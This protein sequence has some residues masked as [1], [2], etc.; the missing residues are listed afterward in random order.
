MDIDSEMEKELNYLSLEQVNALLPE[1]YKLLTKTDRGVYSTPSGELVAL[2]N[3]KTYPSLSL[4]YSVVTDYYLSIGVTKICFSCSKY[5]ALLVP[6]EIIKEY[7]KTSGWKNLNKGRSYHV[8][9]KIRGK[10]KEFFL[11]STE[12]K[13]ID[14][15]QYFFC[16]EAGRGLLMAEPI[17][18]NATKRMET[19]RKQKQEQKNK[20]SNDYYGGWY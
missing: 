6:I 17:I 7:N 10:K 15:T 20:R 16:D 18:E 9:M 3:S 13:D 12:Q 2:V 19:L 8:R 4:W 1:N 5:G 11:F 14:L